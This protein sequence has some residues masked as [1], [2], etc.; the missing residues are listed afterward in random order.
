ML[1]CGLVCLIGFAFL[2]SMLYTMSVG[3][4]NKVFKDFNATLNEDQKK[5]YR[6]IASERLNL[7]LQGLFLGL[8]VAVLAMRLKLGKMLKAKT[9][10]VCAFVV[11]AL[12]INHVYYMGMKKSSYMLNHLDNQKQVDAWLEIYK[13]MKTRKLIGMTI[14]VVGYILVAWAMC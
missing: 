8:I 12:V 3:K 14:G 5:K 4:N 11:I 2:G 7:Y 1:Q 10:K 9:P 13:H 6:E